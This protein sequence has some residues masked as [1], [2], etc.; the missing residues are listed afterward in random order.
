MIFG[1]L[2]F[3]AVW[4]LIALLLRHYPET[5]AGYNTMPKAKREKIDIQKLGRFISNAMFV[6]VPSVLLSPLMPSAELYS[7]LLCW[8]PCG[9]LVVAGIY[10]NV[11]KEKFEKR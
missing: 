11:R 3:A 2:I 5:M 9:M 10:V 6:G 8:I 1:A 4:C 7:L